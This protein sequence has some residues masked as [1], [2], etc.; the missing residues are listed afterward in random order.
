MQVLGASYVSN[1]SGIDAQNIV[2]GQEIRRDHI[3][4][5]RSKRLHLNLKVPMELPYHK[6]LEVLEDQVLQELQVKEDDLLADLTRRFRPFKASIGSELHREYQKVA[7]KRKQVY[8][9]LY[10]CAYR[11]FRREYF[12]HAGSEEV[13]RQILQGPT[14]ESTS[15]FILEDNELLSLLTFVSSAYF[16]GRSFVAHGLFKD[17]SNTQNGLPDHKLLEQMKAMCI[18]DPYILY[19]PREVPINGHCPSCQGLLIELAPKP[20]QQAEHIHKCI[21]QKHQDSCDS[22]FEGC[23]PSRCLWAKCKSNLI[24]KQKYM[25]DSFGEEYLD[26]KVRQRARNIEAKRLHDIRRR[27]I[28]STAISNEVTLSP[29]AMAERAKYIQQ[30]LQNHIRHQVECCWDGCNTY[31]GSEFE[32]KRH[33]RNLHHVMIRR[34]PVEP[35]FCLD[36]PEMGWFECEFEWEDHCST[37]LQNIMK[38]CNLSR[39]YHTIIKGLQ[40]PFCLGNCKLSAADRV[41]QFTL[42][43][44]FNRHMDSH[45]AHAS[46]TGGLI[47]CPHPLCGPESHLGGIHDLKVHFYDFH[48]LPEKGFARS[49][50]K[51]MN[52]CYRAKRLCRGDVS[53]SARKGEVPYIVDFES[54]NSTCGTDEYSDTDGGF[55]GMSDD[56]SICEGSPLGGEWEGFSDSD[57]GANEDR[58]ALSSDINYE[59]ATEGETVYGKGN[60]SVPGPYGQNLAVTEPW[61]YLYKGQGTHSRKRKL[62]PNS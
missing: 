8:R 9:R 17:Y 29:H 20:Y 43:S 13:R 15:D 18:S 45:F 25:L 22:T 51:L 24:R 59:S 35:S 1:I 50:N 61:Q 21:K 33:L 10:D 6:N 52:K 62:R 56:L 46:K 16:P 7:G 49:R 53:Q 41:R 23:L 28:R 42:R 34:S 48:K 11:K 40:C 44:I 60:M 32:L 36:H 12:H 27:D 14:P 3:R 54:I 26:P 47:T 31:C 55:D 38:S 4:L 19:Y 39:R 2:N 58:E 30:H 5:L 37:H 57:E